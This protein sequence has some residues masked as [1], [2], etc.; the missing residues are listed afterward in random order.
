MSN[1]GMIFKIMGKVNTMMKHVDDL[2]DTQFMI[3]MCMMF[4]E[5]HYRHRESKMP[6]EMARLVADQV[7]AVND[8][9]GRY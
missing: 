6:E 2:D 9:C 5:Y 3:L 4:D 1:A 7:K 8:E